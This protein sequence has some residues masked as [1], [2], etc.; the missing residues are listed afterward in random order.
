M[1]HIRRY[2]ESNENRYINLIS[3]FDYSKIYNSKE[4]YNYID[5]QKFQ[6]VIDILEDKKS[7]LKNIF[8]N[9]IE[10]RRILQEVNEL[11]QQI[12]D[13]Q[14]ALY[15]VVYLS[16]SKDNR[17]NAM[18]IIAK[19]QQIKGTKTKSVYVGQLKNFKL[20]TKDP[21]AIEIAKRRMK[22]LLLGKL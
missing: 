11:V 10:F 14:N 7:R 12:R 15:P 22:E 13:I 8:E 19:T 21:E 18:N 20:G 17:T 6:H 16:V 5:E 9:N 2:N 1:K 4:K 3:N